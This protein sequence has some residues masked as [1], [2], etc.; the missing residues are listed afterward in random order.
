M[1]LGLSSS[2]TIGS[3]AAVVI[4]ALESAFWQIFVRCV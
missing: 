4:A 3:V 2:L 1:A